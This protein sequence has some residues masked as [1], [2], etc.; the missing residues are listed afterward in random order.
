MKSGTKKITDWTA[1]KIEYITGSLGYIKLAEKHSLSRSTLT[2]RAQREGWTK[3]REKY[4]KKLGTNMKRQAQ[5]KALNNFDKLNRATDKLINKISKAANELNLH[6]TY[7]KIKREFSVMEK[8]ESGY[9]RRVD[10]TEEHVKQNKM[11]GTV[12]ISSLRQLTAAVRDLQQIV[13]IFEGKQSD[14][15]EKSQYGIVR[16][17]EMQRLL[18]PA[19]DGDDE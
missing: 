5:R 6:V 10:I 12:N 15:E 4:R 11:K 7:D 8:D 3:E 14:Q 2:K 1:I 16:M 13:L 19:M 17:P 18:T 9:N